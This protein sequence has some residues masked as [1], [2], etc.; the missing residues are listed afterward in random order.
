LLEEY[1]VIC[2]IWGKVEEQKALQQEYSTV[3]PATTSAENV[4]VCLASDVL[5]ET[6]L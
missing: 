5:G 3:S 4:L 2:K 6:L 1:G